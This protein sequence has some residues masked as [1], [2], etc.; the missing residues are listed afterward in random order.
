L[1]IVTARYAMKSS[2]TN[3][4]DSSAISVADKEGSIETLL[5][6]DCHLCCQDGI[7]HN[8]IKSPDHR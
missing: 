8:S 5:F 2:S 1:D 4:N 3:P 6:T 7:E